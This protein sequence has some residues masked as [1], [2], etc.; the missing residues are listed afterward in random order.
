M[1]V[2]AVIKAARDSEWHGFK[3]DMKTGDIVMLTD[4]QFRALLD[5]QQ[6]LLRQV[7]VVGMMAAIHHKNEIQEGAKA[8]IEESLRRL[9]GGNNGG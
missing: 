1:T 2:K 6:Y 9:D 8:L 4:E 5:R 7:E 3:V